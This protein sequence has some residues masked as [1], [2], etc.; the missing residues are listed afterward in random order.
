M[1]KVESKIAKN[2]RTVW[3]YPD[4]D[5]Y[6]MAEVPSL[7]GCISQGETRAEALTNIQEAIELH[8]EVLRERG[9]KIPEDNIEVTAV[10]V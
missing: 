6:I 3:L 1:L 10:M 8:L 7:P 2:Q 5:G 4:E 9:E